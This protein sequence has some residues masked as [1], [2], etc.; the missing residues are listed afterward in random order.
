MVT[1][2]RKKKKTPMA[3]AKP[4]CVCGDCDEPRPRLKGYLLMALGLALLP[5]SSG[6]FPEYDWVAKG[7]PILL[8]LF[9]IVFVAK[10]FLCQRR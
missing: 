4:K 1:R 2:R 9:G 10:T 6:F 7:W 8:F 3:K 5:I